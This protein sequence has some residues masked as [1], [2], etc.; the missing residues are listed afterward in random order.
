MNIFN[1]LNELTDLTQNEKVLARYM[2][3]HHEE[4]VKAN[5]TTIARNCFVSTSTIYRLCTKLDLT[6]LTELKVLV[7]SSI[8]EYLRQQSS[9]DYNYPVKYN[10]IHSQIVKKMK[11]LYD[12][13]LI[14][15]DNLIDH[16][17][18]LKIAELLKKAKRIDFYTSAGNIYFAQNF[19]FQMAEIGVEVSVPM[20][21][22]QQ[23]LHA[24]NSKK[25]GVAIIMSFEGRGEIIGHIAK[26]LKHNHTPI[27]LISSTNT[28]PLS[29]L[30]TY[31]LYL[32]SQENHYHKISSFSTRLSLLFLLD[33]IYTYYFES[34]YENNVAKKLANYQKLRI[35]NPD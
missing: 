34:D 16:R 25:D 14:N 18:L 26:T 11:D 28:N 17:Q 23:R 12:Q 9:I 27:I 15:T 20:E 8:D 35:K 29:N 24:A 19:M 32:S 33:C 22:Y 30:A 13:T 6:G 5:A 10:E 2:Q 3:E 1:K 7:S 4:F 31:N 21:E